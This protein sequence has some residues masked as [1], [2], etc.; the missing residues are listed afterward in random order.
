MGNTYPTQE[1][2]AEKLRLIASHL[3]YP[4]SLCLIGSA[5]GMF[6]Q[7]SRVSINLNIWKQH[8]S[9][10][11]TDLKQ[12]VEKAGLLFNPK[13]EMEP[14]TPCIQIVQPGIVQLGK[15]MDT[16]VLLQETGLIVCR[17]PI[18]N[19]I[20]S[21]LVRASPKDIEDIIYL[22]NR[23]GITKQQVETILNTFPPGTLQHNAKENLVYLDIDLPPSPSM[24]S[25]PQPEMRP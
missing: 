23:F 3:Q 7:Q 18:E 6:S 1:Q 21:K 15:F 13:D 17:P 12:A 20:A 10:L 14:D 2:W 22:K 9:F 8:S 4:A 11:Y 24:E 25:D 16:T 5:I 19:I